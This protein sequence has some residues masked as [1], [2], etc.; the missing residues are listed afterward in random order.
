MTTSNDPMHICPKFEGCSAPVCPLDADWPRRI[1]RKGE[2][3]CFYLLEYVKPG[4]RARF[5]GSMAVLLYN[6][7]ESAIGRL[8][9][10]HAPL[11]R[12][13]ERAK[14]TGSRLRTDPLSDERGSVS[15]DDLDIERPGASDPVGAAVQTGDPDS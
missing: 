13:V 4:S 11:R 6:V 14:R 8:C 3:I 15:V 2:P 12:A 9:S 5:Q 1:H 10:R 7:M